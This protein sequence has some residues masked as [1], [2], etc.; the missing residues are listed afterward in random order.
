MAGK[1][2]FV[3]DMTRCNGCHNCQIAFQDLD[4]AEADIN[5]GDIPLG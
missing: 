1:K 2:V 5:L 4:T 3:I